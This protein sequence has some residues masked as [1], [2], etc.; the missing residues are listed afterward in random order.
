MKLFV[1]LEIPGRIR[2]AMRERTERI[3]KALP[4]ASWVAAANYHF[5]LAFL[6][7]REE[8]S[9]GTLGTVLSSIFG[10]R[11]SFEVQ[12][13]GAGSFPPRRPARTLWIGVEDGRELESLHRAV[14]EGLTPVVDLEGDWRPFHAHATV[15]RCPKPWTKRCVDVWCRSCSGRVGDPFTIR[16]G[17]L[18][19]S[20]AGREGITYEVV[21]TY[22]M[23]G[24]H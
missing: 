6:G 16:R 2:M 3:R 4:G 11:E 17:A 14:W 15:A 19:A 13:V 9:A 5:L 7:T 22:P 23:E 8:A 10:S 18:F 21:E 12:L 20:Q 24:F 1:G